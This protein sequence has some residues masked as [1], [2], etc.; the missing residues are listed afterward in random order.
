[1]SSSGFSAVRKPRSISSPPI[2]CRRALDPARAPAA[3]RL[4]SG[5]GSSAASLHAKT[6][7]ADRRNV[8]IGSFNFDPRSAHLNTEMGIV[9]ESP[10]LAQRIADA[11]DSRI[12]ARAYKPRLDSS[13]EMHW[14]ERR[15]GSSVRHEIEPGTTRWQRLAVRL[16]SLLPIEW[17]L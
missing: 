1:M 2:S 9:I 10:A 11:F 15:E 5:S 6:F 12:P 14:I 7:A 4:G 8:F 16:L 3:G 13:G 17:L